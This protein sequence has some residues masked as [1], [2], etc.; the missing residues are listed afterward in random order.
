M[1]Q[2][3]DLSIGESPVAVF[4]IILLGEKVKGDENNMEW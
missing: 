4:L 3:K 1:C 2:A